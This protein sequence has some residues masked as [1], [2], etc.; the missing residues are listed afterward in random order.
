MHGS[1]K[2][3]TIEAPIFEENRMIPARQLPSSR[4][5]IEAVRNRDRLIGYLPE[6]DLR[7]HGD[8]GVRALA[9]R[10]AGEATHSGDPAYPAHT[11]GA[12]RTPSLG[13]GPHV[14]DL[15]GSHTYRSSFRYSWD[16]RAHT[17]SGLR[18]T[19]VVR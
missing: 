9:L 12:G 17:P 1:V 16:L 6:S 14:S 8:A 13:E 5:L 11:I 7:R 15:F 3:D 10:N 2:V 4:D 19:A 18:A